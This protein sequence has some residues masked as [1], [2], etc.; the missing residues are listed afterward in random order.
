LKAIERSSQEILYGIGF[1]ILNGL[2]CIQSRGQYFQQIP[3]TNMIPAINFT[4]KIASL[5][6]SISKGEKDFSHELKPVNIFFLE[7]VQTIME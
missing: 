5:A 6:K 2:L 4:A 7:M 3:N 1:E